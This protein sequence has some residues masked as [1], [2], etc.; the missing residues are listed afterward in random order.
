MQVMTCLFN[1][2]CEHFVYA[3]T[4]KVSLFDTI[5]KCSSWRIL[6]WD[7]CFGMI[8]NTHRCGYHLGLCIPPYTNGS[9]QTYMPLM[10]LLPTAGLV[11]RHWLFHHLGNLSHIDCFYCSLHNITSFLKC[12][13]LDRVTLWNS[14]NISDV[15]VY[16]NVI[17]FW[18]RK[19]M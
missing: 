18:A 17:Y 7:F 13:Q 5:I 10:L 16:L 6:N 15:H 4:S 14:I 3:F 8:L 12:G 19:N 2:F 1:V 9:L 11:E